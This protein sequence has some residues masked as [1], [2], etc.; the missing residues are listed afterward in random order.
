[1]FLQCRNAAWVKVLQ[2]A[3]PDPVIQ[4]TPSR[5]FEPKEGGTALA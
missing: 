1:M 3:A 5:R 4:I 2:S